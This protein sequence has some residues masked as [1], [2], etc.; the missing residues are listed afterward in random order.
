[1]L[2]IL[3]K[4]KWIYYDG[5]GSCSQSWHGLWSQSF[6]T[7]S[8]TNQEWFVAS[9]SSDT[10][11]P[12]WSNSLWSPG[13]LSS[14]PSRYILSPKPP[15]SLRLSHVNHLSCHL[16]IT[17]FSGVPWQSRETL[18]KRPLHD[19]QPPFHVIHPAHLSDHTYAPPCVGYSWPDVL[20]WEISICCKRLV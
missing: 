9:F 11:T 7:P 6:A 16:K 2:F 1:M 14:P 20:K 10:V 5:R 13:H 17:S 18:R 3:F 8:A 12:K 4:S 15:F 19:K